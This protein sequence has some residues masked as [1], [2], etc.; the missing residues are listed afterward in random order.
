MYYRMEID[1]EGLVV[2]ERPLFESIR[3]RFDEISSLEI[4]CKSIV[5]PL[6]SATF[7]LIAQGILL[8]AGRGLITLISMPYSSQ[9]ILTALNMPPI[10]CI[11]AALVRVK[12]VT[13]RIC[14]QVGDRPLV[15]HYV[16]RSVGEKF[17][18]Q[19]SRVRDSTETLEIAD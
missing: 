9:L 19:Y 12:Y 10:L 14:F 15:L 11:L 3:I 4:Y 16:L 7:I 13:L 17:V 6:V 2:I 5:P 8:S 1:K 18:S